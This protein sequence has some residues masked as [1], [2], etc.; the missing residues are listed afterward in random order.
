M[1]V[2]F[3][4]MFI[5]TEFYKSEVEDPV[6]ADLNGL[7]DVETTLLSSCTIVKPEKNFQTLYKIYQQSTIYVILVF[8]INLQGNLPY[9]GVA[10]KKVIPGM[11]STTKTVSMITTFSIFFIMG[12]FTGQQRKWYTLRAVIIVSIARFFLVAFFIIQAVTNSIPILNTVWFAY[13]N[14]A[15]FGLSLGF[16]NVA[17]Y[18]MIPEQVEKQRKEIAGFLTC[19]AINIG[20]MIGGFLALP[21]ENIGLP[22]SSVAAGA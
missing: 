22:S 10:L 5:R 18:Y 14:I 19:I 7:E 9:P 16:G 4:L 3:H 6:A 11:A 12:K 8:M 17:L 15:L 2:V 20:S 1:G 13:V 21:L